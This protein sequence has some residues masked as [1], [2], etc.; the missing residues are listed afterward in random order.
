MAKKSSNDTNRGNFFA[1]GPQDAHEL[2]TEGINLNGVG[3][4][5]PERRAR[6]T[7][8]EWE[9]IG[10]GKHDAKFDEHPDIHELPCDIANAPASS[11]QKSAS[12]GEASP[13]GRGPRK[14]DPKSK[15]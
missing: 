6:Q 1:S 12:F 11:S 8:T 15:R 5:T 9:S 2:G 7:Y 13:P 4:R 10:A 14:N 3:T